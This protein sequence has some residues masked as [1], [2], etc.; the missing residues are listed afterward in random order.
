MKTL[1]LSNLPAGS[2]VRGVLYE[3]PSLVYES[4]DVLEIELPT[5]LTI[6]V[7]W[8]AELQG[9][10]FRVVVYREYFGD[11]FVDFPVRDIH[12]VVIEVQR[13][14]ELYSVRRGPM[15]CSAT[16]STGYMSV[17]LNKTFGLVPVSTGGPPVVSYE[18]A[19]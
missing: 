17:V 1:S 14:A 15:A 5:G 8:D 9:G 2:Q 16:N 12:D 3:D 4:G 7:G 19:C 11:H 13:L 18:K 6:D 10:P